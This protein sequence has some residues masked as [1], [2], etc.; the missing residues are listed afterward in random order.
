MRHSPIGRPLAVLN[1]TIAEIFLGSH[2]CQT[3]WKKILFFSFYVKPLSCN[4]LSIFIGFNYFL[5][6]TQYPF[7]VM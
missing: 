1:Q 7:F 5:T 2:G 4:G 3:C 6:T